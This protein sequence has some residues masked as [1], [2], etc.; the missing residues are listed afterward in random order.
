MMTD[1]EFDIINKTFERLAGMR[2]ETLAHMEALRELLVDVTSGASPK[3]PP[4]QRQGGGIMN[5][6]PM[7]PIE[8]LIPTARDIVE[9]LREFAVQDSPSGKAAVANMHAK[10]LHS[11]LNLIERHLSQKASPPADVGGEAKTIAPDAGKASR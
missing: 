7:I 6:E 9:A 10:T 4:P 8:M 11:C 3:A 2:R 1:R 5:K